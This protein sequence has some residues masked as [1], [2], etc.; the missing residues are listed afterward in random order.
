M[1][2]PTQQEHEQRVLDAQTGWHPMS[3]PH[4]AHEGFGEMMGGP[5]THKMDAPSDVTSWTVIPTTRNVVADDG[6]GMTLRDEWWHVPTLVVEEIERTAAALSTT[7]APLDVE[8]LAALIHDAMPDEHNWR[9]Y[10]QRV[11]EPDGW[12]LEIRRAL[13][14]R[15][16]SAVIAGSEPATGHV[17]GGLPVEGARQ[18]RCGRTARPRRPS[19]GGPPVSGRLG[20]WMETFSGR[21]FWPLD[22]R[23][24]EI[25]PADIAH[26]LS[27]LCRYGGHVDRFYSVAEHCV[28]MSLAV[29]PEHALA[30]LL[31]DATEAYVVDV[32]RPLKR[33]L[34]GYRE[35]EAGV[36]NAICLRF[37]LAGDLPTSVRLADDRILL[38]ERNALMPRAGVW[39]QDAVCDPLPV[40]VSGWGPAQAEARYLARLAEL[41][42]S[43]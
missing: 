4:P 13:S 1:S 3:D 28:L 35:I 21:H 18:G 34:D 17:A 41:G 15:I 25:D 7:P 12:S 29:P 16:A 23:P 24:A 9:P 30:A 19:P 22:P 14:E 31:H 37:R 33:H 6:R 20:D 26:A 38:T 5:N 10:F 40:V 27:L 42:V 36:W 2:D 39:S 32:P 43:P 8:R 11:D